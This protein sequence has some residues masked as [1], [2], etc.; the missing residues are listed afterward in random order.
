MECRHEISG[1][2][3]CVSDMFRLFASI[4][5]LSDAINVIL[6]TCTWQAHL[7]KMNPVDDFERR[8]QGE[9][10][11]PATGIREVFTQLQSDA[12]N[13]DD[14]TLDEI[15]EKLKE[16]REDYHDWQATMAEC[17]VDLVQALMYL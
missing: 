6:A 11:R 5:E 1:A 16:K 2:G 13:D 3:Y 4:T 10:A 12:S 14:G 17:Q 7:A 8:L 15:E 9:P